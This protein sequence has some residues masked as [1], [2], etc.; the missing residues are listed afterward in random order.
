MCM[1][2]FSV[3]GL[4]PVPR[5]SW[6]PEYDDPVNSLNLMGSETI[7]DC[8]IHGTIAGQE[9]E[10]AGGGIEPMMES[11]I[12]KLFGEDSIHMG[13]CGIL[14]SLGGKTEW[15]VDNEQVGVLVDDAGFKE[16]GNLLTAWF[17][18]DCHCS[19]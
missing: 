8:S 4:G 17:S 19:G 18:A 10:P 3:E 6:I 15:L 13:L 2:T 5:R 7:G 16:H 12:G 9:H 1:C 14:G 11:D